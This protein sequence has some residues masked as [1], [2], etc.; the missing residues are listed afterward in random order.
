MVIKSIKMKGAKEL[1]ARLQQLRKDAKDATDRAAYVAGNMVM[2]EAKARAPLD[3][4]TL[5]NSGYVT[6]PQNGKV[7]LGFGG[8]AAEYALYQHEHTEL[9]HDVGE[10]KY[11]ENAIAAVDVPGIIAEE[12]TRGVVDGDTSLPAGAHRTDPD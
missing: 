6:L 5:R 8:A 2:T 12:M 4:G 3:L 11:L 7:E 9:H 10:A 1:R